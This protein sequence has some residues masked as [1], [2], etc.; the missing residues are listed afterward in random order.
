M[1]QNIIVSLVS[2]QTIPN[3]QFIKELSGLPDSGYLFMT[4][5]GMES[6]GV[7]RW[8]TDTCK[9]ES[10]EIILVNE[11]SFD[12]IMS[13]LRGF[14]FGEYKN[15]HVNLTG[16]TKIMTLA[17]FEFF[18]QIEAGIFYVT[19]KEK[20]YL[21]LYPGNEVAQNQMTA[22]IS[23]PE[24]LSSYGFSV[25]KTERCP[26]EYA[27]LKDFFGHYCKIKVEDYKDDFRFLYSKRKRK[28]SE[29]DFFN[30]EKLISAL[31]F[32]SVKPGCLNTDETTFLTGDW[33]EEY[34]G[35]SIKQELSLGDDELLIGGIIS[36][37]VQPYVRNIHA[38]LLGN[39]T[40]LVIEKSD[41]EIDVMFI[42]NNQFYVIECKTSI[43]DIRQ[44]TDSAGKPKEKEINILGETLYKADSLKSKFGL[45]AKTS[46]LTLTDF[47]SYIKDSDQVVMH[48]KTKH[49]EVLI[50]RANHSNIKLVDKSM[51]EKSSSIFNCIK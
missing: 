34:V 36:K 23:V 49:M 6:K 48:N 15:I 32:K 46:I 22:K 29:K 24:Y 51:L 39:L 18:K 50:G 47:Q 20:E 10:A 27:Q 25:K 7:R 5:K 42:Y 1:K 19:G 38:E 9:I 41:N 26:Y 12:D 35:A 28:I 37:D 21:K 45:F 31:A 44:I 14:N 2:D 43:I 33:F 16:G 17:A 40:N 4:T 30:V 13:K 11:F 8:I 3:V